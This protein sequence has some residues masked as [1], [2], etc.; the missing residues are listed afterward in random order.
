MSGG[1]WREADDSDSSISSGSGGGPAGTG[2]GEER[3][4]PAGGEARERAR[5]AG[6][7]PLNDPPEAGPPP[8]PAPGAEAPAEGAASCWS[9]REPVPAGEP[10][11]P[12][13]GSGRAHVVLVC[14]EPALELA[15]GPGRPL[16]LG[17]DP[18]W[19]PCTA[20]AFSGLPKLSRRHA[21]VTVEPDGGAWVEEAVPGSRNHTFVNGA[22]VVPGVRTPL[23][24]GDELRLGLRV[25]AFSVRLY[26]PR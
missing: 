11:C 2:G 6:W 15:R 25:V 13:C 18:D 22:Q 17:R 16:N 20:A 5:P 21:T 24:D 19:A 10:L 14:A 9:C 8:A 4:R 7:V 23:R 3:A 26:G 1:W 12:S